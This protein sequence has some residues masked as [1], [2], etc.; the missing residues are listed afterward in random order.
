[1]LLAEDAGTEGPATEAGAPVLVAETAP[2]KTGWRPVV[3]V[4]GVGAAGVLP[5][6]AAGVLV[7]AGATSSNASVELEGSWLPGTSKA[8]GT[9]VVSTSLVSAAL[10]GCAR[11]G[12]WAACGLALAGPVS[13]TGEGY[14]RSQE[15]SAWMV[16]AGAR[17]QWEWL[18]A[19]PVGLRL[20]LD[21][22]VNVVRPRFLVDSQEAW[23]VPPVSLWVGGGLFGRF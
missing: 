13:G 10:V 21:G 7:H 8:F 1:V 16:S 11:F 2:A 22:A 14:S 12:S 20:H 19:D 6:F 18:F 3:G 9:G 15:A 23:A 17:A 4:D 5:G